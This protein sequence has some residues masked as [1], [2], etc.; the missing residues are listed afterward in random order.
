MDSKCQCNSKKLWT[1]Q[2]VGTKFGGFYNKGESSSTDW[3]DPLITIIQPEYKFLQFCLLDGL[4]GRGWL[5]DWINEWI[6]TFFVEQP[7]TLA[8]F[9][10]QIILLRWPLFND[11]WQGSK[12]FSVAENQ[13]TILR[14]SGINRPSFLTLQI[15][16]K[17]DEH[18]LLPNLLEVMTSYA[19][20]LIAPAAFDQKKN[21][22][23]QFLDFLDNFCV[24]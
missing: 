3:L 4:W 6:L 20:L 9:A 21:P 12:V 17:G 8:R 1:A 24:L 22:F 23:M 15:W 7:L 14:I 5:N 16:S 11:L 2:F 18:F 10:K 13:T 19:G